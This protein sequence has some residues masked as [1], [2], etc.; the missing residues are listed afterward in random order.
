LIRRSKEGVWAVAAANP[1]V[2]LD[3]RPDP[4]FPGCPA[5]DTNAAAFFA[6]LTGRAPSSVCG[7]VPMR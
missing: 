2:R 4:H 1:K 6:S 5:Y 7:G 3:P